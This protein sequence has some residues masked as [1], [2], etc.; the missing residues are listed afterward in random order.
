[1]KQTFSLSV[2]LILLLS[3]GSCATNKFRSAE[4]S[5]SEITDLR[6]FKPIS[7]IEGINKG[8]K[9]EL[10]DSLSFYSSVLW[11]DVLKQNDFRIPLGKEI[12]IDDPYFNTEL[13]KQTIRFFDQLIMAGNVGNV[14]VP[15]LVVAVLDDEKNRFG[16]LTI[17]AGFTRRKG[18]YGGQ[19][20]KA[21][22]IGILTLGMY[23]PVPTKANSS[24]FVAIIDN[25]TSKTIFYNRSILTDKEPLDPKVLDKQINKLFKRYFW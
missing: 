19:V 24:V 1:M 16:L 14:E 13:E 18:N 22:G 21:V 23:A 11:V 9:A 5:P 3:L 17:H 4:V 12:E 2:T 7:F 8:N 15:P 25:S 6:I 10:S 20:A